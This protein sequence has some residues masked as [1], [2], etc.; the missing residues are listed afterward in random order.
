MSARSAVRAI[1]RQ[2]ATL[3]RRLQTSSHR[4]F[5]LTKRY[6]VSKAKGPITGSFRLFKAALQLI[7]RN[8]RLF[9]P[10]VAIYLIVYW[11][12]IGF[13]SQE[14][15]EN[16]TR[17]ATE[18]G[19]VIASIGAQIL[20]ATQG[21]FLQPQA[22]VDQF[23]VTLLG[24]IF[25]LTFIWAVRHISAGNRISV[26][27][28][29]YNSST[30]LVT[31]LVVLAIIALQLIPASIGG[32]VLFYVFGSGSV[33]GVEAMLF[34]IGGFLL[35]VLSLYFV[36]HSLMALIIVTLPN[37]FPLE[38]LTNAKQLVAD[39]RVTLLRRLIGLA[40]CLSLLWV[41]VLLPLIIINTFIDL[42]PVPLV[43]LAIDILSA[44]NLPISVVYLY[45][46]YRDLL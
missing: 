32:L 7:K 22:P 27:E 31:T 18:S 40:F 42:G 5:R 8:Y 23:A 12:F 44:L 14:A 21:T 20:G 28:A 29:L 36:L 19:N 13:P 6:K 45:L 34:A 43:P 11:L 39:R 24:L 30:P 2:I 9:L 1:G 3:R 17:T 33:S 41:V 16:A 46:L 10:L 38:S 4:S 15:Y 37:M 25:W 35:V 26:R